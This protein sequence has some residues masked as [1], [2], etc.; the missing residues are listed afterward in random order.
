MHSCVHALCRTRSRRSPADEGLG[1]IPAGSSWALDG[2]VLCRH[3]LQS[4]QRRPEL[5]GT[6][7]LQ[8]TSHQPRLVC[9]EEGSGLHGSYE[10]WAL[11]LFSN[12]TRLSSFSS[13]NSRSPPHSQVGS[14]PGM[15]STDSPQTSCRRFTGTLKCCVIT[16]SLSLMTRPTSNE[17]HSGTIERAVG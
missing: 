4:A 7:C 2:D 10:S 13:S 1:A 6:S 12:S 9:R 16:S 11:A 3:A 15:L 17:L 5:S 8:G 14:T